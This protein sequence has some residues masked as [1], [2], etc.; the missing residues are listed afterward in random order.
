D[1]HDFAPNATGTVS[2]SADIAGSFEQPTASFM[3]SSSGV[4]VGS[5]HVDNVQLAGDYADGLHAVLSGTVH[6]F[7]PGTSYPGPSAIDISATAAFRDNVLRI[8]DAN[9]QANASRVSD[10]SLEVNLTDKQIRGNV[11]TIRIDLNDF[12]MEALGVVNLAADIGGTLDQPTAFFAGSSAGLDIGGTHIDTVGLEG[13]YESDTLTLTQLDA[14]QGEGV[15]NATGNVNLSTEAVS[16]EARISDLKVV[17]VPGLT[18]TAFVKARAGGTYR[19]PTIDFSREL[20]DVV[21]RQE[22]H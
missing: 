17:Q 14:R 21:Y 20:R 7:A 5:I 9:A 22:E 15:L 18:T 1:L 16:A 6:P 8:Q 4:D 12:A 10:A 13:R 2:L 11:P 3:G 19:S